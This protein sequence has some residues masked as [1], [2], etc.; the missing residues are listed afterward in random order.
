MKH[1][2]FGAWII[3]LACLGLLILPLFACSGAQPVNTPQR[4]EVLLRLVINENGQ[5]ESIEVV[6]ADPPGHFD[7]SVINTFREKKFTPA[8]KDGIPV[9]STIFIHVTVRGS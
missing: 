7:A 1:K 6:K 4:S 5:V 2:W 9:K 3:N 8:T